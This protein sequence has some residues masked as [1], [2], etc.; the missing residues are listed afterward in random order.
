MSPKSR[1]RCF[2]V[3]DC[4]LLIISSTHKQSKYELTVT[5]GFSVAKICL[6]LS[7]LCFFTAFILGTQIPCAQ[8]WCTTLQINL[9]YPLITVLKIVGK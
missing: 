5:D 6:F 8:N 7:F 4:W 9:K 2:C 1:L 3:T